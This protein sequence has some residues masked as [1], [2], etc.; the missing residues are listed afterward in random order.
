M[1]RSRSIIRLMIAGALGALILGIAVLYSWARRMAVAGQ[2]SWLVSKL[3]MFVE[4]TG[5]L[6]E[7]AHEFVVHIVPSNEA[8]K[9]EANINATYEFSEASISDVAAWRKDF[10]VLRKAD[11]KRQQKVNFMLAGHL[12]GLIREK[13]VRYA[14]K[15]SAETRR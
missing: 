3:A 14:E 1:K 5:R 11:A 2:D 4:E 12:R 6:P 8:A 15:N 7:D 10:L 9:V 13:K